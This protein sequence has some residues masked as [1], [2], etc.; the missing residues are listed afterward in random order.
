M[1]DM[2]E[3]MTRKAP[4]CYDKSMAVP[5]ASV[6]SET[7]RSSTQPNQKPLGPREA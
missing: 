5:K 6:N 3:G 7:T 4:P 2:H 1:K